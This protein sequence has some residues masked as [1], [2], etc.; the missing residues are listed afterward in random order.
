MPEVLLDKYQCVRCGQCVLSCP[1]LLFSR[2]NQKECPTLHPQIAEKC[3]NCG[4]CVA[5]CPVGAISV[6]S[7]GSEACLSI[8][9]ESIPRFEHISTLVRMRRSIR[10]YADKHL[11]KSKLEILLD[12]VR[13]APSARNGQPIR[14]I[15]VHGREKVVELA[16]LVIDWMRTLEECQPLVDAWE[17]GNDVIFRGA[18]VVV[19]ACTGPEAIYPEIDSAIAVQTL[20]FCASS[21][22]LG[23]CW[24]GYFMKAAQHEPTIAKWLELEE[25]EKVQAAL[26]LGYPGSEAYNRIPSRDEL[27][28]RW[29]F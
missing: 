7:L 6:N 27:Q 19:A 5:G 25:G 22:R 12:V 20:D 2:K 11:E 23:T 4:H 16:T 17:S 10:D 28:L 13:W 24:A 29:I 15:V 21:M 18:P 8:P 14:W 9:K 1:G 26:M 3:I